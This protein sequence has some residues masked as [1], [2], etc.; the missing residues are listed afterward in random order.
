MNVSAREFFHFGY[1]LWDFSLEQLKKLASGMIE[2]GK[3]RQSADQASGAADGLIRS[4]VL[5]TG[6]VERSEIEALEQRL[7]VL[8]NKV[9]ND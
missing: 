3:T 9:L 7:S 8:E 4:V 6:L 2:R 1:G 5:K